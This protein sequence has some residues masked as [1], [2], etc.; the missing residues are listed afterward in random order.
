MSPGGMFF[1]AIERAGMKPVISDRDILAIQAV[2]KG[3][4][5]LVKSQIEFKTALT[6]VGIFEF[7]RLEESWQR[8]FR[9]HLESINFGPVLYD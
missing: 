6:A 7:Q 1:A 4:A 8:E 5:L 2:G 9:C 3:L